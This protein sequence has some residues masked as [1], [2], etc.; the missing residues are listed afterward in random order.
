MQSQDREAVE[1]T[2]RTYVEG[3][4]HGDRER[5]ERVFHPKMSE[6]GHFRGDLMWNDREEFI[7]LC[8]EAVN[9]DAPVSWRILNLSVAGDIASVHIEDDWAGLSFDDYLLLLRSDGRWQIV[10]KAFRVRP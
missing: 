1:A 2:V 7:R 10:A 9:P 6:I 5:L 4:V 3:M 8:Q